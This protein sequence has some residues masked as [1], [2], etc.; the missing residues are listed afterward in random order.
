MSSSHSYLYVF[1][2]FLFLGGWCSFHNDSAAKKRLAELCVYSIESEI[3]GLKKAATSY[4]SFHKASSATEQVH[5]D[6][7]FQEPVKL[8]ASSALSEHTNKHEHMHTHT[9]LNK[10]HGSG[11]L[12]SV[13]ILSIFRDDSCSDRCYFMLCLFSIQH[14]SPVAAV[15]LKFQYVE[16]GLILSFYSKKCNELPINILVGNI[17][18]I[19]KYDQYFPQNFS[20]MLVV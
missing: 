8:L 13:S 20:H 2:C 15:Q 10:F 16:F 17:G 12:R 1:F 5:N 19:L 6:K 14:V 7:C 3:D 4:R 11:E 9:A 18:N